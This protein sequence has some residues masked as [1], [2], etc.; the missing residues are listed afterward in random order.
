MTHGCI[1]FPRGSA[2]TL[3]HE[4][5]ELPT[6]HGGLNIPYRGRA[7]YWR[8]GANSVPLLPHL[9]IAPQFPSHPSASP[10][11]TR[12]RA[13]RMKSVLVATAA[14]AMAAPTFTQWAAQHGKGECCVILER[15]VTIFVLLRSM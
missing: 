14:S 5:L 4:S 13:C 1:R 11:L 2:C 3:Y 10:C 6:P 15:G 9:R 12:A 8:G 7:P